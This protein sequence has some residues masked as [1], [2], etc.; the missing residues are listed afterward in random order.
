[1]RRFRRET[2]AN[3]N[4]EAVPRDEL[5]PETR[6][7]VTVGIDFA[8]LKTNSGRAQRTEEALVHACS[9]KEVELGHRAIEIVEALECT[10]CIHIIDMEA[11]A[12]HELLT[13]VARRAVGARVA[14]L[15]G[16]SGGAE[17]VVVVEI[18]HESAA[19]EQ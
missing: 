1:L 9:W 16:Q 13:I 10:D 17:L 11:G 14:D 8:A 3:R 18:A 2:L 7:R 19:G 5:A 12:E 4:T 6:A 15:V